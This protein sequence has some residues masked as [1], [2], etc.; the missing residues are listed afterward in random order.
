MIYISDL[1]NFLL[2]HL[3]RWRSM[4]FFRL[5]GLLK[6]RLQI[7]H[8]KGHSPLCT[9]MWLF[10]SPGVGNDLE[11]WEHLWGFSWIKQIQK[12]INFAICSIIFDAFSRWIIMQSVNFSQVQV[13]LIIHYN[14]WSLKA[15][16]CAIRDRC[17]SYC[18]S[19]KK[20]WGWVARERTI[21]RSTH[22]WNLL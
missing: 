14:L 3:P 16:L 9:Y 17:R 18:G 6:P 21:E 5:V 2:E 8:R 11:H 13:L 10:K 22:K 15:T 7:W 4:W 20:K 19:N 12:N 1:M